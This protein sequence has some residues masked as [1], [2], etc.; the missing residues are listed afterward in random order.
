MNLRRLVTATAALAAALAFPVRA[1]DAQALQVAGLA[2]TC[3]N[4]HG[5][6]GRPVGSALPTL[7]GMNKDAMLEQL[8]AFRSG[9]RPATIMHQLTRG[10]S[11]AQ[12]E[13]IATYLSR[14][15]R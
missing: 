9:A 7:A 15:P 5:T 12:L 6:Q 14:Q 4:C 2:A 10:Y 13:Q 1:Q 8:R 3:A 11:D